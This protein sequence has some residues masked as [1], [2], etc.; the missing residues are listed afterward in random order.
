M[1]KTLDQRRI[2][3]KKSLKDVAAETGIKESNVHFH[4]RRGR[5][6][7]LEHAL[8]YT[9]YYGCSPEAILKGYLQNRGQ[10]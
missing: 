6:P 5:I 4:H 3:K 9:D 8:I 1:A 7:S 2:A 10:R